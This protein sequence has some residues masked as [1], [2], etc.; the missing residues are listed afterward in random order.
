MV[1]VRL[2]SNYLGTPYKNIEFI[3][4][5]EDQLPGLYKV[6]QMVVIGQER[7]S[8]KRINTENDLL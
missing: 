5:A 2:A 6:F 1:C 4:G 8:Q 3:F 7:I